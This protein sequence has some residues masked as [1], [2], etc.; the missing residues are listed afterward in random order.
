MTDERRD[1][2][3]RLRLVND[4]PD[5]FVCG[6]RITRANFISVETGASIPVHAH[7]ECCEGHMSEG[8]IDKWLFEKMW[9]AVRAAILGQGET[10]NPAPAVLHGDFR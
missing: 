2:D 3:P 9:Q 8:R 6:H 5:C 10:P 7:S 1:L 4:L